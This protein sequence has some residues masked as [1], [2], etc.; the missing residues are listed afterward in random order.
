MC[1]GK[2]L[3][4]KIKKKYSLLVFTEG[5]KLKQS[6]HETHE[7]RRRLTAGFVL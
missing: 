5:T 1:S 7:V 6:T 3:T 4:I 2:T